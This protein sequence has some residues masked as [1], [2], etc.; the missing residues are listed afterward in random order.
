MN[1]LIDFILILA[2]IKRT[3]LNHNMKKSTLIFDVLLAL[4]FSLISNIT[5]AQ[6][7]SGAAKKRIA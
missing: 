1:Q 3:Y 2:V 4:T 6:S 5:Y 7:E